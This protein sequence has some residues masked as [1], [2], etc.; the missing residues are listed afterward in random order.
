MLDK[1]IAG[2]I[3]VRENAAKPV[4]WNKK[5]TGIIDRIL[6][7]IERKNLEVKLGIHR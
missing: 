1:S 2:G 6:K 3:S 7:W 5:D 4:S